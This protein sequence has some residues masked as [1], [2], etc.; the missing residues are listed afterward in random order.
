MY[1]SVSAI[2]LG[3]AMWLR[4]G[5]WLPR[6]ESD[7]QEQV[8]TMKAFLITAG[9]VFGLVVVAHVARMFSEPQLVREPWFW[10]LTV[11]SAALSAWAWRLLLVR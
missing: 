9:T 1:L 7:R 8:P 5:R 2:L 6:L 10:A 3:E 11:L 4:S